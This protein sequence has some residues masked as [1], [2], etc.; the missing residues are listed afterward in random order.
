MIQGAKHGCN[1]N[2]LLMGVIFGESI[3]FLLYLNDF[4]KNITTR[5]LSREVNIFEYGRSS[6]L[7]V[8]WLR[9][10]RYSLIGVTLVTVARRQRGSPLPLEKPFR[11][12]QCDK[13]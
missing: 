2:I 5:L 3:T 11:Y 4:N 8:E 10:L 12:D 13:Q 6:D 1:C 7:K 9:T